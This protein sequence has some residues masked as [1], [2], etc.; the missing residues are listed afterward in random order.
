M[1]W[2]RG[3]SNPLDSRTRIWEQVVYLG[4]DIRENGECVV[5]HIGKGGELLQ[6]ALMS[7]CVDNQALRDQG[8][9]SCAHWIGLLPVLPASPEYS[10]GHRTPSSK[11]IQVFEVGYCPSV[12]NLSTEASGVFQMTQGIWAWHQYWHLWKRASVPRGMHSAQR[13]NHLL[14]QINGMFPNVALYLEPN[15]LTGHSQ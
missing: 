10:C 7:H 12:S 14:W 6:R 3:S 8:E 11:G 4:S 15:I 5:S 1:S 2:V 13:Y 9:Q